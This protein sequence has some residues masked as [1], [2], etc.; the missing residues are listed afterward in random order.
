MPVGRVFNAAQNQVLI[1][2]VSNYY[3]GEGKRASLRQADANLEL[4]QARTET[5]DD[6]LDPENKERALAL[7]KQKRGFFQR[8]N[9]LALVGLGQ[10]FDDTSIG[11]FDQFLLEQ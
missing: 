11:M 4:T 10:M 2:P 6:A 1:S 9:A 7:Y 5:L 3:E 8:A